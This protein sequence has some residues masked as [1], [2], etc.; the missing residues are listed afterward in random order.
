MR[1]YLCFE[2]E[3][4]Q[5]GENRVYYDCVVLLARPSVPVPVTFVSPVAIAMLT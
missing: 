2:V 5:T 4:A 3:A 1:V